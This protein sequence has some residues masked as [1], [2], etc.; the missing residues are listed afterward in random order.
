MSKEETKQHFVEICET[1]W[2]K[3]ESRQKLD[4]ENAKSMR[5]IVVNLAMVAWNICLTKKSFSETEKALKKL[6]AE[7][8]ENSQCALI[9]FL[10]TAKLKWHEY[11]DDHEFIA[12]AEVKTVDGKPKAVAYLKG[13]CPEV[14][15]SSGTFQ[16]F[17]D[18]PE[19]QARLNHTAPE[20]LEEEIGKTV[21]EYNANLPVSAVMTDSIMGNNK[22]GERD[23]PITR[24]ELE[25]T[26]D[27]LQKHTSEGRKEEMLKEL[28]NVQP[29]L[30]PLCKKP[31][32]SLQRPLE[33]FTEDP[34][35]AVTENSIPD[36]LLTLA[37]AY[38][39]DTHLMSFDKK[40]QRQ[41]KDI[42]R[43]LAVGFIDDKDKF[44]SMLESF[45]ESNLFAFLAETL[46]KFDFSPKEFKQMLIALATWGFMIE[47][48]RR[49][50]HP[51]HYEEF[52]DSGPEEEHYDFD[53]KNLHALQLHV[54]LLGYRCSADVLVREDTTFEELH[55]FLN[56]LFQR[57]DD[58]LYR[59]ECEDGCTAVRDEEDIDDD[60]VLSSECYVGHHLSPGSGAY[61]LF[62][63]GDEWEHDITVKKI[64]PV[65]PKENYPKFIKITG[66]IPEQYP[67]YDDD[68]GEDE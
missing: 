40:N 47:E 39:P 20:K 22:I 7:N 33:L 27:F 13:E 34:K 64:I 12:K 35:F 32:Q 31:T 25:F 23:F 46:E 63:Y 3:I 2:D 18:S 60:E 68:D 48:S 57:D 5:Y 17:M 45:P 53:E 15:A 24:D 28:L 41:L 1:I 58:H 19:I 61:Y 56:P 66:K 10:E 36:I 6:A 49:M 9:P 21:A 29:F 14:S 62:D 52:E 43:D 54:K 30:A 44:Y 51:E 42:A 4:V 55:D 11:R 67:D 59:F 8:C 26:Y 16:T 38:M 50:Q 65:D 37:S